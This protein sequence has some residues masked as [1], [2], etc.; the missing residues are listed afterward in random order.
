MGVDSSDL[1]VIC[2]GGIYP[3]MM[4]C[5]HGVA[6]ILV[7]LCFIAEKE[8][9]MAK[10]PSNKTTQLRERMRKDLGYARSYPK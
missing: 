7:S 9:A 6:E 3:Q 2:L 8:P 5:L 4:L 1:R 10:Q